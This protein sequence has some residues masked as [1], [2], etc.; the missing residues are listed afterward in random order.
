M[1]SPID[2]LVARAD[3]ALIV[4]T[5]ASHDQRAG[6]LVGFHTQCS[7]DPFRY[8]VWLSKA[9]HTYRVGLFATHFAVH[10]LGDG[11][12]DLAELFGAES[13]DSV[14]KFAGIDWTAGEGEVPVL[15]R[16]PAV[17]FEK[18]AMWDDGGDH[19]CLMGTPLRITGGTDSDPLR[20]SAARAIEP[21]HAAEERPVPDV[22]HPGAGAD[23]GAHADAD[24]GELQEIAAGFGHEL[25]PD[26]LDALESERSTANEDDRAE[27]TE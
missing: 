7:I 25:T 27:P 8:A 6:C 26:Q 17:V 13:G 22:A 5:T 3:Q 11:D 21:G 16:C 15:T 2:D 20:I 1:S 9:N 24:A 19:V 12:G 23:V 14:D 4:V 10:F 18:R